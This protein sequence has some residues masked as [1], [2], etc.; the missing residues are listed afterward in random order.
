MFKTG[1]R[2]GLRSAFLRGGIVLAGLTQNAL[3]A[4]ETF[5][6]ALPVAKGEFLFREQFLYNTNGPN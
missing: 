3:A 1:F 5:N 2:S 4:P 6:T